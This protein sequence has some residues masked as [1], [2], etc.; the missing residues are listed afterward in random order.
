MEEITQWHVT[1]YG[2]LTDRW[3]KEI[4]GVAFVTVKIYFYEG[5]YYQELWNN[6]YCVHYSIV[7]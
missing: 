6:G 5:E 4:N 7:N 1:K 3:D 2:T